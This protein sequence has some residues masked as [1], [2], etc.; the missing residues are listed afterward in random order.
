MQQE[1]LSQTLETCHSSSGGHAAITNKR[2]GVDLFPCNR[3]LVERDLK[4]PGQ[5]AAEGLL[6]LFSKRWW[7]RRRRSAR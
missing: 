4:D 6:N 3:Q 5:G 2:F 7:R 1:M